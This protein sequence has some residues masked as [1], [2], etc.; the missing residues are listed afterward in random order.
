VEWRI[1]N[2]ELVRLVLRV[3]HGKVEAARSRRRR[4]IFPGY[5]GA[6]PATGPRAGRAVSKTTRLMKEAAN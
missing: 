4:I 3:R 1:S 5:A 6:A 2:G